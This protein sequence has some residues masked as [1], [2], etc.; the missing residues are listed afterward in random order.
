MPLR[1]SSFSIFHTCRLDTAE[2]PKVSA[3]AWK[4]SPSDW[5]RF[6]RAIEITATKPRSPPARTMWRC[7]SDWNRRLPQRKVRLHG[8]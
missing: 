2:T 3:D 4:R 6:A 1:E 8:L 5:K 7:P